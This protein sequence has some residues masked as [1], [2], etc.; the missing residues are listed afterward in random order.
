MEKQDAPWLF[1][2]RGRVVSSYP[3]LLLFEPFGAA[4]AAGCGQFRKVA[5]IKHY[6]S[7]VTSASLSEN[8]C[9]AMTQKQQQQ[10]KLLL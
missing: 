6:R 10:K 1:S 9:T 2:I 3:D 4:V 8:P 5:Y 7:L